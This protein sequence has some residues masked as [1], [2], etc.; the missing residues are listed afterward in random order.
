[1]N[2]YSNCQCYTYI[3][4][5]FA[6]I[7]RQYAL[8]LSRLVELKPL[9]LLGLHNGV[10]E[11]LDHDKPAMATGIREGLQNRLPPISIQ[12]VGSLL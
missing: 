6:L 8:V 7:E 10:V 12:F 9:R 11:E 2:L 4:V 5:D 3:L 1:M